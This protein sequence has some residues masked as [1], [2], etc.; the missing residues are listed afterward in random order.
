[1]TYF[2]AKYSVGEA[3]GNQSISGQNMRPSPLCD[4]A[5]LPVSLLPSPP[6]DNTSAILLDAFVDVVL[7]FDIKL[8]F[9]DPEWPLS[10]FWRLHLATARDQVSAA[11]R[12]AIEKHVTDWPD[13]DW[14]GMDALQFVHLP[15]TTQTDSGLRALWDKKIAQGTPAVA[16]LLLLSDYLDRT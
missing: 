11:R 9:D 10:T 12:D 16:L 4:E 8:P 7:D 3:S 14:S 15:Q 13:A 1:M 5:A 6:G 2:G